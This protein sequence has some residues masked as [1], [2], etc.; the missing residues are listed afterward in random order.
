MCLE[1]GFRKPTKKQEEGHGWKVFR[2]NMGGEFEARSRVRPTGRWINEKDFRDGRK[3]IL[4]EGPG[5]HI[6]LS[7]EQAEGWCWDGQIMKRVKYRN[8][9]AI[10][11]FGYGREN[12][13]AK[14]IFIEDV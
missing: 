2:G 7:R 6:F 12:I 13:V 10:G 8:A 9:T 11:G 1:P 4:P 3:K 14:E 5:F